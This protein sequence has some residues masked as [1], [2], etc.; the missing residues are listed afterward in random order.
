M[1]QVKAGQSMLKRE[2]AVLAEV[3]DGCQVLPI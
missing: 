3:E 2:K 1:R